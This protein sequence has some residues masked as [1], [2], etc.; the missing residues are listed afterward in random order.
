MAWG[1]GPRSRD[2]GVSV[3]DA[4]ASELSNAVRGWRSKSLRDEMMGRSMLAN[5]RNLLLI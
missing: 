5:G 4:E 3:A 1:L 2:A